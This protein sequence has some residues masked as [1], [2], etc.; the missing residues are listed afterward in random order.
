M[1]L[2][3]R[4]LSKL[5]SVVLSHEVQSWVVSRFYLAPSDSKYCRWRNIKYHLNLFLYILL[6]IYWNDTLA[7][8]SLRSIIKSPLAFSNTYLTM[9]LENPQLFEKVKSNSPIQHSAVTAQIQNQHTTKSMLP[10]IDSENLCILDHVNTEIK[11]DS[12]SES[13]KV[14]KKGC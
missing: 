8:T 9:P 2:N 4:A 1:N 10:T 7:L 3:C 11:G 6:E 5:Y 14:S 12:G 13:G